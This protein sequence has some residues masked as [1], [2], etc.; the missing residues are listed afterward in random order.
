[1]VMSEPAVTITLRKEEIERA[2]EAHLELFMNRGTLS[3]KEKAL[4]LSL[5]RFFHNI[6]AQ[7]GVEPKENE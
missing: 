1:M 7:A 4:Y 3:D 5:F 2:Y 6:M